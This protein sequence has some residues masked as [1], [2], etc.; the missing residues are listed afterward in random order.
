MMIK[1]VMKE[2]LKVQKE[3]LVL[4]LR[5][6]IPD[7]MREVIIYKLREKTKTKFGVV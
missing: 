5:E 6:G 2:F 4:F 7:N 3:A 1:D